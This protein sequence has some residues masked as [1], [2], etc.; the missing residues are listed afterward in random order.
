MQ[1]RR[2]NRGSTNGDLLPL[3]TSDTGRKNTS[4]MRAERRGRQRLNRK[5]SGSA[6][7][8]CMVSIVLFALFMA[9]LGL[10]LLTDFDYVSHHPNI[11]NENN[12]GAAAGAT[13]ATTKTTTTSEDV[14]HVLPKF[15]SLEYAMANS[16]IVGLYFAA[17]W[18]SMS[19]PISEK[20]EGL[21]SSDSSPLKDRVLS[22][23][24]DH[25]EQIIDNKKDFAIVYVSSDETEQEMVGYTRNNWFD[26]PFDSADRNN[27]KRHFRICAQVEMDSLG[28]SRRRN[29]IPSLVIID[30]L[31]NGI[32]SLNGKEDI[33]EY[34]EDVLDHWIARKDLVRGL[35][36]KYTD[37]E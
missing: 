37:E 15:K 27:L 30:S 20:I 9:V 7:R 24:H 17:S 21:F 35:E 28:I 32:L 18:C 25:D 26:V 4:A 31:R 33:L 11:V 19:T 29:E 13:T 6:N 23:P 1:K 12:V 34:G 10:I 14:L 16:H 2:V 36:D 22:I 3:T 5:G 8:S